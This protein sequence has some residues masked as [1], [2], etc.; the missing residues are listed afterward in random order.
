[1]SGMTKVAAML[2]ALTLVLVAAD[3]SGTWE[4]DANFDDA[5]VSGGGFDCSF[6]QD[7][8][9]LT[10]DCMGNALTGEVRGQQVSWRMPAGKT[11]DTVS[12]TATVNEDGRTMKG[13]FSVG[14]KG[15][16]IDGRKH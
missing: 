16:R 5:S 11:P 7:G 6:T 13:R 15:G 3:V 10:G 4:I 14:G 12:V 1:M 2:V 8:E 9:R